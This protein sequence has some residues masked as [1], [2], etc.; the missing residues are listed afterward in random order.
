[1]YNNT[2]R[3]V[4][5]ESITIDNSENQ[6]V[7]VYLVKQKDDTTDTTV[8]D[9][10]YSVDVKVLGTSSDPQTT[11]VTNMTY[12]EGQAGNE[13]LLSYTGAT[14]PAGKTLTEALHVSAGDEGLQNPGTATRIYDVTIEVYRKKNGG[15]AAT[16]E[17][18]DLLTTLDGTKME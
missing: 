14:L 18:E 12:N 10:K 3:G 1:M 9:A 4:P 16:Y 13:M 15:G 8:A 7:G 5:T 6:E 2:A 17:K 11:V